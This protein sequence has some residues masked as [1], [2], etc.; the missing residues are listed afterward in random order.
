MM[1]IMKNQ[2]KQTKFNKHVH[3]NETMN[4]DSMM[5]VVEMVNNGGN[6]YHYV[7]YDSVHDHDLFLDRV[8]DHDR[9][10]GLSNVDFVVDIV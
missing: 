10:H 2:S 3:G 4:I 5:K 7:Y 8:L 6:G 9:D 1:T